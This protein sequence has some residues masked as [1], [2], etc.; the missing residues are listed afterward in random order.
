MNGLY[1][2]FYR[3]LNTEKTDTEHI[4]AN[5]SEYAYA[6]FKQIMQVKGVRYFYIIKTTKYE[7]VG[8]VHL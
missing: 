1:V 5:T 7:M 4:Y 2:I 8:N 6:Q 3:D